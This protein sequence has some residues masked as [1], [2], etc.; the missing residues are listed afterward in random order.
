MPS[1][2]LRVSTNLPD[3]TVRD[4]IH[5]GYLWLRKQV[6]VATVW[7]LILTFIGLSSGKLRLWFDLSVTNLSG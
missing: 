7:L 1:L 4:A 3:I 2:T 6:A 5:K